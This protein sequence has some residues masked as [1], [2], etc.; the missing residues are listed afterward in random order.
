MSMLYKLCL[1]DYVNFPF[2]AVERS[3]GQE[4]TSVVIRGTITPGLSGNCHG[5]VDMRVKK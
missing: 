1:S 2:T 3:S 5:C 4:L